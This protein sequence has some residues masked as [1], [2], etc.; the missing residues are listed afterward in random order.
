[1][2]VRVLTVLCVCQ[3]SATALNGLGWYYSTLGKDDRKAV[4][5]FELAAG[6][7]SRDGVF[8][9]GVYHLKGANPD[10]PWQNEVSSSFC[11]FC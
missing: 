4:Y 3:G 6:N 5:Y 11:E 10:T 9:L 7:G 8:N 1:M 2:Y